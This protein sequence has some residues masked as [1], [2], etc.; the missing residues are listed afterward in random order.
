[1]SRRNP[2]ILVL[3]AVAVVALAFRP[4]SSTEDARR[5]GRTAG[6]TGV[7]TR[8]GS[9]ASLREAPEVVLD[10]GIARANFLPEGWDGEPPETAVQLTRAEREQMEIFRTGARAR[11]A[12]GTVFVG[13]EEQDNGGSSSRGGGR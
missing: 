12:N 9:T 7:E 8:S 4:T 13:A 1:M 10:L 2:L 6:S 11:M 3:V 5:G